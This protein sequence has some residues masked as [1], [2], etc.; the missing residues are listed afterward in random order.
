MHMVAP[1][2]GWTGGTSRS[3]HQIISRRWCAACMLIGEVREVQGSR[4]PLQRAAFPLSIEGRGTHR[5]VGMHL[6]CYY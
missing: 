1:G 3:R 2:F 6:T 5:H 4:Q